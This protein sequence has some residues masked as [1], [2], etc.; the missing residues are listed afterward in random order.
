M[1][2][3]QPNPR[4]AKVHH[5]YTVDETSRLFSVHKNTVRHWLKLGLPT[6]DDS[7]PC[8]ILGRDL[9]AFLESRRANKKRPCGQNELYCVRCRAPRAPAGGMVDYQ[10]TGNGLGNLTAI[11]PEC[12]TLMNRRASL[13]TLQQFEAVFQVTF[14]VALRR[15]AESGLPGV[16]S[17][18]G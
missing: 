16:N 3:R 8:L 10:P 11:C 13:G 15:I 14:P 6:N 9:R 7:R 1:N 17:D 5:S 18:F 2:R 4:L 12:S